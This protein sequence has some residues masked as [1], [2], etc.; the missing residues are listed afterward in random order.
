MSFFL[1]SLAAGLKASLLSLGKIALILIPLFLGLELAKELGW[2]GRVSS[3]LA[4]TLRRVGLPERVALPLATGTIIGFT[5][6]AGVILKAIQEEGWT[7]R[8]MM[9]LWVFLGLS[10]ALIEDTAIFAALGIPV[11]AALAVRLVP[12]LAATWI[13]SL[14]LRRRE[15]AR[16]LY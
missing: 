7:R 4:G 1:E 5:Y 6:G 16:P 3:G 12:A 10:H 9:L 15:K 8:E 13:M 2:L 14:W 11:P